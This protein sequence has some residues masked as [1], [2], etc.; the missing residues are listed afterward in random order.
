MGGIIIAT[1]VVLFCA[2]VFIGIGIFA[3]NKKS[4]MHFWSGTE[5]KAAEIS[6]VR[7][8]NRA[9][10]IMWIVYGSAYVLAAMLGLVFRN[11]IGVA[12]IIN[13]TLGLIILII[14]YRHIYRKY[15]I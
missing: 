10:G 6:N 7:A 12:I 4:P 2:I 11:A 13:C 15:K 14:A 8:Y 9:N 3:L 5:V 1:V